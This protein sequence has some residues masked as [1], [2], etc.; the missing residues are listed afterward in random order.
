MN[1]NNTIKGSILSFFIIFCFSLNAQDSEADTEMVDKLHQEYKTNG[2]ESALSMYKKMPE[3]NEYQGLQE[4]LNVLG[5]RL[6]NGDNDADAA[7]MVFKAQ[8]QEHPDEPNPYDSYA[9]ALIEKGNDEEAMKQLDKSIE[10]L[11]NAEDNDFN[12]NLKLASKSKLAKL[13]GLNKVF[14]FL[15]GEWKVENYGFED[16]EKVLRYTD[17]VSFIP[18]KMNS[19]MVMRTSNDE[20][21]WEGTQLIAYDALDN[22]YDVVR[23]NNINLNGVQTADMKIEEYSTNKLVLIETNEKNGEKMKSRHVIEKNGDS[24]DWVIYDITEDGE[25]KVSQRVMKKK[26]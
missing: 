15:D 4:P 20:D 5:Y 26:N 13:K 25:E 1:L 9:D 7:A 11:R 19:A 18:S 17:D 12:N 22:S 14:S 2:V 23:T 3:D 24:A 8:V 21:G 16:G 10:L 6:L